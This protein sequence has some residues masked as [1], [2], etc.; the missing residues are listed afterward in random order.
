M[1]CSFVSEFR[2]AHGSVRAVGHQVVGAFAVMALLWLRPQRTL[3]GDVVRELAAVVAPGGKCFE[4]RFLEG[5]PYEKSEIPSLAETLQSFSGASLEDRVARS[6]YEDRLDSLLAALRLE[7]DLFIFVQGAEASHLQ[8][9]LKTEG[10]G[11][12]SKPK[13][14]EC[15]ALPTW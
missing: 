14:P 8:D 9:A 10:K 12:Y 1:V 4:F 11:D 15:E 2:S 13:R 5:F 7:V 6:R 3:G